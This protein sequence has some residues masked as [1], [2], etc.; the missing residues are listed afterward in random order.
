MPSYRDE[1]R[2]KRKISRQT[3]VRIGS[4]I[5][6]IFACMFYGS[7]VLFTKTIVANVPSFMHVSLNA[8]DSRLVEDRR[9]L[10]RAG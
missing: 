9:A 5:A 10:E 7:V 8:T 2:R 3:Q 1:K 4:E 6:Q